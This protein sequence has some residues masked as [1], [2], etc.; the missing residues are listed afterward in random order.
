MYSLQLPSLFTRSGSYL[1]CNSLK[2]DFTLGTI[3]SWQDWSLGLHSALGSGTN[4][5]YQTISSSSL[6]PWDTVTLLLLLLLLLLLAVVELIPVLAPPN[7][8]AL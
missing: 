6:H 3:T 7:L 8:L 1:C 4:T 5:L 2:S